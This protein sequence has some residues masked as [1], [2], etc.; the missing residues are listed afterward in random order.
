MRPP[1]TSHPAPPSGSCSELAT[2]IK[3][4]KAL[5][6]PLDAEGKRPAS[7][8][9]AEIAALEAVRACVL[10]GHVC[11]LIRQ[12]CSMMLDDWG[13]AVALCRSE[14][15][16]NILLPLTCAGAQIADRQEAER[17]AQQL[18]QPAAG[19]GR[20]DQRVGRLQHLPAHR[21]VGW[22]LDGLVDSG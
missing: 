2:T 10:G 1:R 22:W 20:Y 7:P 13:I 16:V 11:L 12:L 6:P 15:K 3:E 8:L 18:G 17:E 19:P 14:L 21:W 5:L 4:K 9:D